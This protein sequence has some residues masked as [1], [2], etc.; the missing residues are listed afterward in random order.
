MFYR[1]GY[2]IIWV[3]VLALAITFPTEQSVLGD[4]VWSTIVLSLLILGGSA[5]ATEAAISYDGLKIGRA[6]FSIAL[7]AVV[8]AFFM[9]HAVWP[10]LVMLA[11]G[12]FLSLG[13][14]YRE[15]A[16][17]TAG[18]DVLSTK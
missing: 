9:G 4:T 12:S 18:N 13:M 16:K 5:A 1:I 7:I 6:F 8:V 2:S 3:V 17:S 14:A 10:G 11:F 15:R